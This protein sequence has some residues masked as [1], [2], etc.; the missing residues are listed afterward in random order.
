MPARS[1]ARRPARCRSSVERVRLQMGLGARVLHDA[2]SVARHRGDPSR[3]AA[4]KSSC[5]TAPPTGRRWRSVRR[6]LPPDV[7]ALV[8]DSVV[9]RDGPDTVQRSTFAAVPRVLEQLCAQRPARASPPT[10]RRPR[11]PRRAHAACAR[12]AAHVYDGSGPPATRDAS[13]RPARRRWSAGDL[14]PGAARGAARG[15]AS[16]LAATRPLLRLRRSRR[17][18][19]PSPPREPPGGRLRRRSTKRCSRPPGARSRLPWRARAPAASARAKPL[20]LIALPARG[21]LVAVRRG[22][23]LRGGLVPGLPGLAGRLAPTA[24][25]SRCR[26]CPRSSSPALGRPAYADLQRARGRR[27]DP[28]RPARGRAPIP[29]TRCSAAT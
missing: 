14:E 11:A 28:R 15:G 1:K 2:G 22:R 10:G 13:G 20:D 29:A 17:A 4:T 19:D 24:G 23:R 12:C 26:R 27:D 18:S 3:P 21:R 9:P 8:L 25:K 6:T 16:A 7:E 5:S